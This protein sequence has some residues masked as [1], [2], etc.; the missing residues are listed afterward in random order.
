MI[1]AGVQMSLP[2]LGTLLLSDVTLGLLARV[3]PQMHVFFLG[4]PLKVGIG[5]LALTVALSFILPG[6]SDLLR[7][8]GERTLEIL[9]T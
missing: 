8:I 1:T 5:L 2:L 9:G 3:A 7:S 6:L 4:I